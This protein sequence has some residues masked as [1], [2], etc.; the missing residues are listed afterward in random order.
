MV[1]YVT[2]RRVSTKEQGK[3]GLGLEAQDRDIHIFLESYSPEPWEVVAEYVE[4]HSGSDDERPELQRAIRTAKKENAILLVAKLDR[5]SRK[6][7]FLASLMDDK[8]LNFKVATMP[9]ADKFQLHIYAALAEQERDF[10][11]QRTRNALQAA[12]ANGKKLGWSIPSRVTEQRTAALKGNQAN[13]EQADQFASN[14]LPI[15]REI[16]GA[17]ITTLK[18]LA[19]ALNAR[20]VRTAR[21]GIWHKTTVANLKRRTAA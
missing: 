21:G 7:S 3:S 4:V 6:V 2:Y 12:K 8:R 11:S 17:G 10:I 13:R 14:V 1:R 5:L 16:E 20:G 9:N 18:G 15:I 19:E